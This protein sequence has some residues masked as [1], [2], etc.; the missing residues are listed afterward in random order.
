V[1]GLAGS[2][3]RIY[4]VWLAIGVGI[5][6][7]LDVGRSGVEGV[8]ALVVEGDCFECPRSFLDVGAGANFI[9]SEEDGAG[10][11]ALGVWVEEGVPLLLRK[12]LAR[13][14]LAVCSG[15]KPFCINKIIICH[16]ECAWLNSE[17]YIC[18]I[19]IQSNRLLKLIITGAMWSFG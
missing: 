11:V 6:A 12:D 1:E 19:A 16:S 13:M 15:L 10:G 5:P 14:S 7:L 18:M 3:S 8:V 4:G 2:H 17:P 9:I